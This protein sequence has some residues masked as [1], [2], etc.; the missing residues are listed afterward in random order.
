MGVMRF[1]IHPNEVKNGWTDLHRAYISGYDRCVHPTRVEIDGNSMACR[2]QTSDSGK[3]HVA[4]PIPGF[5]CPVVSTSSLREQD[6]PYILTLELARG[7]IA[8]IRDQLSDWEIAGMKIP[9]EF[10]PSHRKAYRYFSQATAF[11][12]DA[13][14]CSDLAL[15]ALNHA[16]R[17]SELLTSA[18]TSQ[19]LV[20]RRGRSGHLPALLGCNL[21]SI[22]PDEQQSKLF[23]PAF[24]SAAVPIE[25][26]H[27][28]PTEGE[29]FWE[30]N[31]AQVDWCEKNH[32]VMRGGP[33]LDLSAGGLPAWIGQ[34]DHDF[35]NML[36][37]IN[38]FVETAISRYMG[39]I[40]IWEVSSRVNTGGAL[41]IT[42]ENR[43]ALVAKTLEV[44]HQVDE[45]ADLSIR[46]DQ[47]WGD[48][49]ARGQHRL[50]PLQFVDALNRSGVGLSAINLE[51]SVGFQPR[52]TASRDPLDFSKLIDLWSTLG[53]PLHVTL[54]FPSS[55]DEDEHSHSDLEVDADRWKSPW[56]EQAQSDWI[57]LYL[58]LLLA[59][60]AV[61]GIFWTHFSDASPHEFPHAGL[62][63]Q[64]GSPKV[65]LES[66][67]QH[68][69]N[70]WS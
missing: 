28:E 37:F 29:Y 43:L 64:D 14:K 42:E 6:E 5:G 12:D 62:L 3:L 46:I 31:D 35:L 68:N 52:G 50:S 26:K 51:F 10:Y 56:S 34:W 25:W 67:I 4:W 55:A 18:Y 38:D 19:R 41:A 66:L 20:L 8:Q 33:L 11:Q 65:A 60:P 40:R 17:A 39:R 30:L 22:V 23:C 58:P 49:Q 59:K 53:L 2:R 54:A 69:K 48:Y 27:I 63:R 32:L 70:H 57:D 44:A 45:E 15:N 7:K 47:P 13:E 21:E 9:A 1:L 24:N 61:T 36:S 16:Y